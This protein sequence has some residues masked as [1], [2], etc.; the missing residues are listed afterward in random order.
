MI[1]IGI[2][3]ILIAMGLSGCTTNNNQN[4]AQGNPLLYVI[5]N[6][7]T[8]RNPDNQEITQ[9]FVEI[10]NIDTEA[11]SFT[12]N[13]NF[14]TVD[15]SITGSGDYGG[16]QTPGSDTSGIDHYQIQKQ[17]SISPH[18]TIK[19][20]CDTTPQPGSIITTSWD[21]TVTPPTKTQ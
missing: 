8:T 13:F 17:S 11:G 14:E 9:V 16:G 15:L 2:I 21:Y 4:K 12:V 10:Q 6:T 18:E 7:G 5:T 20:Y 19:I 1:I 3:V